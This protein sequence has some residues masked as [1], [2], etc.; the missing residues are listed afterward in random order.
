MR[1]ENYHMLEG[2]SVI[3]YLTTMKEY[4][5]QLKKM[6]EIITNSTHTATILRNVPESWPNVSQ[7][8]RMITC[9]PDTIKEW[10]EAHKP[11]LNALKISTPAATAFIAQSRPY[12]QTT[13]R[14]HFQNTPP[15]QFNNFQSNSHQKLVPAPIIHVI[16][17]RSSVTTHLTVTLW[18]ADRKGRHPG[19]WVKGSS[20]TILHW[21]QIILCPHKSWINR[22]IS[23]QTLYPQCLPNWP[24]NRRN[25]LW[26]L[27][28]I[29][30]HPIHLIECKLPS[31]Y[32]PSQHW[33]LMN[34]SG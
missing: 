16:T 7:M 26:W 34:T 19:K 31:I 20:I 4:R 30:Y 1:H 27:L 12:Q 15:T 14:P 33:H 18:E 21:F 29:R 25:T 10:L 8:I 28:H 17:A 22:K 9:D 32:R 6:G 24:Q 5:S 13:T 23:W 11:D 3:T 2:Q